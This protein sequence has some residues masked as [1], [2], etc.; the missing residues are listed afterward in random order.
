MIHIQ[1]L[2]VLFRSK[3]QQQSFLHWSYCL[4]TFLSLPAETMMCGLNYWLRPAL[5]INLDLIIITYLGR[6][7]F[8][9]QFYW[10]KWEHWEKCAIKYANNCVFICK[11]C[12]NVDPD[13]LKW[14]I[15]SLRLVIS[16][17]QPKSSPYKGFPHS[18]S[19]TA[20]RHS[21]T[22]EKEQDDLPPLWL[23]QFENI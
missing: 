10:F 7:I 6:L 20:I 16:I 18:S 21:V 19:P 1:D 3:R 4:E 22:G 17:I 2:T 13:C 15:M 5:N 9:A 23:I 8:W 12:S 14:W 11:I